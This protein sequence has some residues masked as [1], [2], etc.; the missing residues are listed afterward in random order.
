MKMMTRVFAGIVLSCI[1]GVSA[2]QSFPNKPIRLIV[3]FPPGGGTDVL[4]REAAL[5]VARNTGWNIVTENRPGSGGNIGVDMVAKADPD[6]YSIVLG[7]TS[8]L[9]IN[10]TLFPNLSY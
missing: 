2:A 10:P 5:R 7:Q 1:T 6:G 8:N 9:A 4:A 3:P